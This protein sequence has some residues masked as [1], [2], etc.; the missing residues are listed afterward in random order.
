MTL[1]G[2]LFDTPEYLTKLA[3]KEAVVVL[4]ALIEFIQ[5]A[6]AIG[7]AIGLYP[8]LKRYHGALALGSVG[9]RIVEGV[10]VIVA[11]LSLLSLLSLSQEFIRAGVSDISS[12]QTVGTSLLAIRYWA[13]NVIVLIAFQLGALLYYYVLYQSKL[14]PRWLSGWG[15]GGAAL[16]FAVTV[17]S[18]FNPDFALSSYNTLLNAPIGFQEMVFAVWLIVK[19]FNLTAI[20]SMPAL[21]DKH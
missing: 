19:G 4:A 3:E 14:I 7:I 15:F 10:T 11:A 17:F 18:A 1:L 12:F 20:N 8:L 5:A 2:P 16:S 21:T 13:H 9:F 6:T